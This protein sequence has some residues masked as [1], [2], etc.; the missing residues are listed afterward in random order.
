MFPHA[1]IIIDKCVE[2]GMKVE[3]IIAFCKGDSALER[4]VI[5]DN[6]NKYM[7]K[8]KKREKAWDI[9]IYDFIM[10]NYKKISY[11]MMEGI[12]PILYSR[13]FVWIF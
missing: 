8:I 1:D 10:E 13:E 4:N 9:K 7:D 2:K 3:E 12:L 6:F 11:F 5:I